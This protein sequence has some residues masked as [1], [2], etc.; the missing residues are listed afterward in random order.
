MAYC[1]DS[2]GIGHLRRTMAI[3]ERIGATFEQ[4]SF[5]L[6]TGTPYVPLFDQIARTDYVKLPALAKDADG[7]Y[8]SKYL[9]ISS[10]E[11]MHCRESLLLQAAKYFNPDVLLIDKAPLGVCREL[12]P[13][14]RWMHRHRPHARI[15]FGMRDIEDDPQPTIEQWTRDGVYDALARYFDE[16]WVYGVREVFDPVSEYRLPSAIQSKLHFMGYV[17]R[18]GCRHPAPSHAEGGVLVTVGGGTDGEALLDAYLSRAASEVAA[19][20]LKSTVVGGPDLPEP[21]ASR[22][23]AKAAAL[24]GIDWMDFEPCMPCRIRHADLVVCMGGYNT[25]CELAHLRRPA[26]VYPRTKPRLEQA[27]R[28]RLW[29][30]L[31]IV[32][33]LPPAQLSPEYLARRIA[34]LLARGVRQTQHALDMGGLDRVT[35]R[36]RSFWPQEAGRCA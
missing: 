19:S 18:G 6:A 16:V 15:V 22:L 24:H 11:V 33:H 7:C 4:A 31:G 23:R 35:E 5:L 1:H 3:C 30:Q 32:T 28:A 34:E 13:T 10:A 26:L 8:G 2:V 29:D 9:G 12:M 21:A 14:I 36:F 20:G 17:T 27:I 25:L